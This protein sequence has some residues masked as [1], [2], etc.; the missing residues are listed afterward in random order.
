[1]RLGVVCVL[2]MALAGGCQA[3]G[4]GRGRGG[5]GSRGSGSK[6]RLAQKRKA[7]KREAAPK[8]VIRASERMTKNI[9]I[10]LPLDAEVETHY[11]PEF[12]ESV[13]CEVV[14]VTEGG[15]VIVVQVP[16]DYELIEGEEL[17]I[18][19]SISPLPRSKYL[20]DHRKELYVARAVVVE[21]GEGEC[22]AEVS[23]FFAE[24][25]VE[26]GDLAIARGY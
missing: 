12:P 15:S 5:G 23:D 8:V 14:R 2:V 17:S 24:G 16:E 3:T 21:G 25:P 13:V 26:P 18:F 6:S 22:S 9:D 19:M 10:P 20:K 7:R 1:M 11:A 4:G